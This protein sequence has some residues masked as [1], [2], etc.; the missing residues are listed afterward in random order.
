[1]ME[2]DFRRFRIRVFLA[3]VVF[4]FMVGASR[5]LFVALFNHRLAGGP[6]SRL[7]FGVKPLVYALMLVFGLLGY[8]AVM[9]AVR[10]LVRRLSGSGEEAGARTASIAVP[11]ILIAVHGGLW[12]IGTTAFYAMYGFKTPGG[13]AYAVSLPLTVSWGLAAGCLSALMVEDA[14][15]PLKRRLGIHDIRAGEADYFA[16]IK[17]PL[18]AAATAC[19][20]SFSLVHVDDYYIAKAATGGAGLGGGRAVAVLCVILVCVAYGAALLVYS[21]RN[22]RMRLAS[23]CD[24][25]E[26]FAAGSGDLSGRVDIE[27][28]DGTGK[29]GA[30]INSFIDR[31]AAMIARI[32]RVAEEASRAV[33]VLRS[34]VGENDRFLRE[35]E[36]AVSGA[37]AAF[38]AQKRKIVS[39]DESAAKIAAG[40]ETNL[41][42]AR[43]QERAL[44]ETGSTVE[45][46][47]TGVRDVSG[48]ARRIKTRADEFSATMSAL[49]ATIKELFSLMDRLSDR[50]GAMREGAAGIADIAERINLISLNASIEAAHAGERGKG[51]AVVAGEVRTLAART[52]SGADGI[53]ARIGEVAEVASSCVR[54]IE[55]IRTSLALIEPAVDDIESNLS[56]LAAAG[57][58]ERLGVDRITSSMRT[59]IEAAA[60][61]RALSED[62]RERA[63]AIAEGLAD[64]GTVAEGT[65]GLSGQLRDR[66]ARLAASNAQIAEL[67]E[68]QSALADELRSMTSLFKI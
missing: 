47:L 20:L 9:R 53:G 34:S 55:R 23:L 16:K 31:L 24:R 29:V 62:Q 50:T 68:R 3:N 5:E 8:A 2:Q 25:I 65:E 60:T 22:L 58:A 43:S 56:I 15:A 40:T 33:E 1:M 19:A 17:D 61:V 36:G 52:A 10:P 37:L 27:S 46:L 35:F 28:F 44:A 57:D 67:A 12:I 63:K 59:G 18:G 49:S 13:V 11:W 66:A 26:Q 38:S 41:E 21:R 32:N 54:A 14:L 42:A 48:G 64:L 6:A 51:F 7:A 4:P 45:A 39:A 30:S